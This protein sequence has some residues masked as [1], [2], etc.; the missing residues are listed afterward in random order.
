MAKGHIA[1]GC[2]AAS[3]LAA[4]MAAV[5]FLSPVAEAAASSYRYDSLG[6]LRK[7]CNTTLSQGYRTDYSLDSADNRS[8]YR[9]VRTDFIINRNTGIVS[10]DNRFR[11]TLEADGNL[12]LYQNSTGPLWSSNTANSGT[13]RAYFQPDGN[14]VLYRA[15]D[16]STWHSETYMYP[17]S[18]LELQNDGNLVIT[19]LDGKPV[20]QTGTGGH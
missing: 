12:V 5:P 16:T 17:C 1:R 15:N 8:A 19:N 13:D 7:S 14:L 4:G 6:R 3:I 10:P 20:W 9:N 11:L 2:I 18:K